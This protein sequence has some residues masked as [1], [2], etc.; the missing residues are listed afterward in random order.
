MHSEPVSTVTKAY[1]WFFFKR[2]GALRPSSKFQEPSSREAST[3][4]FQT[5]RNRVTASSL[6]GFA[7]SSAPTG[8]SA[9]SH[10]R[11]PVVRK[12]T[13][14]S[15]ARGEGEGVEGRGMVADSVAPFGAKSSLFP[16]PRVPLRYTRG[17]QPALLWSEGSKYA[18]FG[19]M[20]RRIASLLRRTGR[21]WWDA[22]GSSPHPFPSASNVR[23]FRHRPWKP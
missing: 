13:E 7:L 3:A 10:G 21:R 6:G 9:G 14:L 4:K 5:A 17:Y 15:P 16:F 19:I 1:P 20:P 18:R 8:A 22:P 2:E 23:I 12:K 11:E